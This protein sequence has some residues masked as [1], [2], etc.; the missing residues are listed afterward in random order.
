VHITANVVSSNPAEA[1]CTRYNIIFQFSWWRKP[2]Y[3]EKNTD[4]PQVNDKLDHILL[5]R[6]HLAW[7][8][9]ELTTLAVICTLED[10]G[11]KFPV[12]IVDIPPMTIMKCSSQYFMLEW[13]QTLWTKNQNPASSFPIQFPSLTPPSS[14]LIF[15][16]TVL[17]NV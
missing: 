9:F 7:V 3:P 15:E 8:G 14:F 5:Y 16:I 13:T 2:Q 17:F 11:F 6:V 12:R 10:T 4:L 1:R